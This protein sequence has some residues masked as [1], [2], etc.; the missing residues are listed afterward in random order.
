MK[1]EITKQKTLADFD[2]VEGS[3]YVDGTKPPDYTQVEKQ[4]PPQHLKTE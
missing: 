4:I 3:C 2:Y 1:Q